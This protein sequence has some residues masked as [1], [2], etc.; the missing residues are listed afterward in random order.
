MAN[1]SVPRGETP[2]F[3]TLAVV[4]ANHSLGRG[5]FEG[6]QPTIY[7]GQYVLG[8][9]AARAP[10]RAGYEGPPSRPVEVPVADEGPK[11]SAA[12]RSMWPGLR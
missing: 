8:S 7:P 2:M 9:P 6:F 5:P 1:M 12:A 11:S 3:S 10:S 4:L